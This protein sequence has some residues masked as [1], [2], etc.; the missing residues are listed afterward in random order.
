MKKKHLKTENKYIINE[1]A[2]NENMNKTKKGN[3]KIFNN[4]ENKNKNKYTN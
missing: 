4:K 3:W 2:N 1:K